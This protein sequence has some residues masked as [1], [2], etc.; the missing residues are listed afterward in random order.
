M[1]SKTNYVNGS[2]L[3]LFVGGAAIGH[4]TTHTTTF[5]SE[6]KDRAVKPV[7]SASLSSGLWKAKGVVGLSISISAEGLSFYDETESGFATLLAL[8]KEGESVEVQALE[9]E[10]DDAPYLV[11]SFVITSL[12]QTAPAQD[13]VTYTINLENDGEPTT[14]DAS[15]IT[16]NST[17]TE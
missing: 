9:R 2:D 5:N 12:E 13:D 15:N 10:S 14:F 1:A 6:T 8:W 16:V 4:C 17:T 3:L 7:A 11:G